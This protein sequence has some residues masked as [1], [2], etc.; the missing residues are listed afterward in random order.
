MEE[1]GETH[2]KPRLASS[3]SSCRPSPVR[4]TALHEPALALAFS[5]CIGQCGT[6]GGA[7]LAGLVAGERTPEVYLGS[8]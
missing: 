2:R 1:E 7:L 3:R 8:L 5:C 6:P 4:K